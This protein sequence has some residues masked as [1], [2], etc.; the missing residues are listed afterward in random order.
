MQPVLPSLLQRFIADELQRAPGLIERVVFLALNQLRQPRQKLPT[1]AEERIW[2]DLAVALSQQRERFAQGFVDA[3]AHQAELD[4]MR[5]H[6]GYAPDGRSGEPSRL[7]LMDDVDL[8]ADVELARVVEQIQDVAEWEQRELQTF[9]STI[10]GREHV[11]PESNPFRGEVM[12]R[13]LWFAVDA[14]PISRGHQVLLMHVLGE[15]LAQTLK[16]HYAAASTRLESQGVEPSRYRTGVPSSTVGNAMLAAS[17]AQTSGS[18]LPAPAANPTAQP[19]DLQLETLP[20]PF[21]DLSPPTVR[22][23]A[24]AAGA[25]AE[26]Q[27]ARAAVE[28]QVVA[29]VSK[30]FSELDAL[31]GVH[32]ELRH[33]M[34]RVRDLVQRDALRDPRVLDTDDAHAGWQLLNRALHQAYCHPDPQD[35]RS[36]AYAAFASGAFDGV[37]A[38]TG[39]EPSSQ[40]LGRL[41]ERLDAFAQ[42]QFNAQLAE[43]AADIELLVAAEKSRR[44]LPPAA[45]V[46]GARPGVTADEPFAA[47][48]GLDVLDTMPA[49]L[50]DAADQP[51][52]AGAL[53]WLERQQP[54]RWYRLWREGRWQLV[55]LLWRSPQHG[56]WL[57]AGERPGRRDG[58]TRDLLL[59]LRAAGQF[60]ALGEED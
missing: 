38:T 9:T 54:G 25:N 21:A 32:P 26:L 36:A 22:S 20:M 27:A 59:R 43:A 10:A 29:L 60:L 51:I 23:G 58:A 48:G 55:Q 4:L 35:P 15:A 31:P 30:R 24:S 42:R 6:Q 5:H 50:A 11:T 19:L 13:A 12:A 34:R 47:P 37:A 33:V 40:A 7:T 44:G 16:L 2:G 18:R 8:A 46:A 53:S 49:A 57:F 1:P 28:R 39:G 17:D 52:P 56:H 14:L 3:L 45:A 41:V